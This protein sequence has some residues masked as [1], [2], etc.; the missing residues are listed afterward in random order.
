MAEMG[1]LLSSLSVLPLSSERRRTLTTFGM[2]FYFC[3]FTAENSTV[4][5][6]TCASNYAIT[7]DILLALVV[8]NDT[9][10][11]ELYQGTKSRSN[12]TKLECQIYTKK[13]NFSQKICAFLCLDYLL[14]AVFKSLVPW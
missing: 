3:Y 5:L 4:K 7:S 10:Q 14:F 9:L 13:H 8:L 12:K 1:F 11:I 6:I 2:P